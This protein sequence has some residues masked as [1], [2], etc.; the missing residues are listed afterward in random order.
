METSAFAS[1]KNEILP[2]GGGSISGIVSKDYYGDNLVLALNTSDDVLM[3][4]SRCELLDINDFLLKLL[5]RIFNLLF[6]TLI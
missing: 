6:T 4:G 2:S 1:F 5:A 3:D